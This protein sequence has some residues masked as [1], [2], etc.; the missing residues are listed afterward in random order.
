MLLLLFSLPNYNVTIPFTRQLNTKP[1]IGYTLV[2]ENN[3]VKLKYEDG[4]Y[5]LSFLKSL[6]NVKNSADLLPL[7]LKQSYHTDVSYDLKDD[8]VYLKYKLKTDDQ[9]FNNI[10]NE[11]FYNKLQILRNTYFIISDL[12]DNGY[13]YYLNPTNLVYDDNWHPSIIYVGYRNLLSPLD[14]SEVDLLR[15]YKCLC[16]QTFDTKYDFDSLYNGTLETIKKSTLVT[17]I[18]QANTI[19]ELHDILN[20]LY[21]LEK[22]KFT[23]KMKLVS[24]QSNTTLKIVSTISIVLTLISIVVVANAYLKTIPYLE[25]MNVVATNFISNDYGKVISNLKDKKPKDLPAAQQ[26]MLAYSYILSEPLNEESKASALK[27]ISA[28]SDERILS[29][30]IYLGRE[31]YQQALNLSK[32]L[33]DLNMQYHASFRALEIIKNDKSI[34]G[35]EKEELLTKYQAEFDKLEE[36]LFG[37]EDEK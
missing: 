13:T 24:R 36:T 35:S 5:T 10:K 19:V 23:S 20:E 15:Q 27:S 37:E 1:W 17:K 14:Q 25:K 7:I 26:Y 21:H 4:S 11:L 28:K 16:I 30:W 6:S 29:Y 34:S 3:E 31:D 18:D 8:M 12:E 33:T 9:S 22:K 32:E 2:I